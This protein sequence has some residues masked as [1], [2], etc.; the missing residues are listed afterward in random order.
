MSRSSA[1]SRLAGQQFEFG[2]Q[3]GVSPILCYDPPGRVVATIYPNHT[4]QKVV[5]DPWHPGG[6][7]RQ[8]IRS[9]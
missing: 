4:Y 5:F 9:P 1:S 6:L 2:M 8:R 3:A 7:G